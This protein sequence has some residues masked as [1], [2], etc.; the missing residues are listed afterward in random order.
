MCIFLAINQGQSQFLIPDKPSKPIYPIQDY[1]NVLSK[2][3]INTLNKK[4]IQYYRKTSTEI[5][6]PIVQDLHGED[7]NVISQ[8]WGEKWKIGKYYKNNGIVILLS[9]N[10]RKI[11]I[12]NGYG[13]EPYI[14]DLLTKQIINNIK[15]YLKK[16]LYYQAINSCTDEIFSILKNNFIKKNNQK[17][18]LNMIFLYGILFIMIMYFLC[19]RHCMNFS[20]FDTFMMTHFFSSNYKNFSENEDSFDGFGDGGN[21]GGGG[22]SEKWDDN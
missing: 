8:K 12:Q 4:L 10:D 13:I 11:S 6:V 14:T 5:L 9:I 1:A 15:P 19:R 3:E 22:S 16:K 2:K 17:E 20:I 18:N 21:F 7:P